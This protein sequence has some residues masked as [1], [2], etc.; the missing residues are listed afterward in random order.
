M[1]FKYIPGLTITPKSTTPETN[2]KPKIGRDQL[3]MLQACGVNSWNNLRSYIQ[4]AKREN[5][6]TQIDA[7]NP[8]DN[9]RFRIVTSEDLGFENDGENRLYE[10]NIVVRDVILDLS[11]LQI[12][13]SMVVEFTNCV[14]IGD[15]IISMSDRILCKVYLDRC[16]VLG[17][18]VIHNVHS[19]GCSVAIESTNC[20]ALEIWAQKSSLLISQGAGCLHCT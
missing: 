17:R 8:S 20:F 1:S 15:L 4:L 12:R 11:D 13:D 6:E 3:Q 2:V 14:I 10:P 18:I 19:L 7:S 5:A 16:L 9:G